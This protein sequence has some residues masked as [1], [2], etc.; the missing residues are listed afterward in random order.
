MGV[1]LAACFLASTTAAQQ[2]PAAG[3]INKLGLDLYRFH[4]AGQ[5]NLC[6]S[7]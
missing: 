6:L 5:G 7:P 4:A 2:D 3:A 1:T